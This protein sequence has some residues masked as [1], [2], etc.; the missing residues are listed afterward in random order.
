MADLKLAKLPDRTPAK[1][2]IAVSAELNPALRQ[3]ADY[4]NGR[5]VSPSWKPARQLDSPHLAVGETRCP[6]LGG[7]K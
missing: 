4:P 2:T 3:Y 1:I 5:H 6:A 7:W